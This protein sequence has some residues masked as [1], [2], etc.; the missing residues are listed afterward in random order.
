MIGFSAHLSLLFAFV[1]FSKTTDAFPPAQ[2]PGFPWRPAVWTDLEMAQM[3]LIV[4]NSITP[5]GRTYQKWP[6]G[7]IPE[8]CSFSFPGES[9]D[10]E[11][12]DVWY[13]DYL[14]L[15][16]TLDNLGRLPFTLRDPIRYIIVHDS[17][18]WKPRESGYISSMFVNNPDVGFFLNQETR[19]VDPSGMPG[20]D[21]W[22]HSL[23]SLAVHYSYNDGAIDYS[24]FDIG[25]DE[26]FHNDSAI[27][28]DR[29]N[30]TDYHTF[31]DI[32]TITAFDSLFP[33]GLE[34]LTQQLSPRTSEFSWKQMA[35][36]ITYIKS[37][38]DEEFHPAKGSKCSRP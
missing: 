29:G 24:D 11:A 19:I 23:G 17:K 2:S 21:I 9:H 27:P 33:G 32:F 6:S 12:Y 28:V 4:A 35:H 18:P 22:L 10:S 38:L 36:Q 14:V 16:N 34:N 8:P 13:E 25:Y 3:G 30:S 20:F 5:M 15:Q 26:A 31:A 7:I 37:L 1:A